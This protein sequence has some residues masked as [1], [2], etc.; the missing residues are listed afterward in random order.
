MIVEL[1]DTT[2]V[3]LSEI[4]N[5]QM[6]RK[7]VAMTYGMALCSSANTDWGKVNRAIINRWSFSTLEWIKNAAW[8]AAPDPKEK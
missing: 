5:P 1:V 2:N 3:L 8:K 4:G 7:D 6:H